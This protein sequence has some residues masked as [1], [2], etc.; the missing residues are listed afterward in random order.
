MCNDG[1]VSS[2]NNWY[3]T[4]EN[5]FLIHE[6]PLHDLTVGVWC[7]MNPKQ[8]IEPV[9]YM[10]TTGSDRCVRLIDGILCTS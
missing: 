8:N 4:F 3:W 5:L 1:H 7:F 6:V 2:Q 10:K 9:S